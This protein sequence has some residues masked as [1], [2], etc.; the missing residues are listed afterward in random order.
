MSVGVVTMSWMARVMVRMSMSLMSMRV[1]SWKTDV[2]WVNWV[3]V[4]SSYHTSWNVSVR[5]F[6]VNSRMT[7]MTLVARMTWVI[8]MTMDAWM[9]SMSR[10]ALVAWMTWMTLVAWMAWITLDAWMA[11]MTCLYMLSLML[12]VLLIETHFITD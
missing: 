10:M 1:L 3:S 5:G 4:V 11:W 8:R 9:A 2:S 12:T 6:W 7:W